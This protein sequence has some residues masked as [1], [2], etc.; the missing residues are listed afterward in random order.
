MALERM[1]IV[2]TFALNAA[3]TFALGLVVAKFLGP[4][5]FGRYAVA[6]SVATVINTAAFEWLRLSATRFYSE[7]ARRDDAGVRA[8]LALGYGA[9]VLTLAALLAAAALLRLDLGLPTGLLA[10]ATVAG[11]AMGLFDYQAALARARF[12]DRTYAALVLAKNALGFALMV[13]GAV[14]FGDPTLVLYGSALSALAA[15]VAARRAL[16]DPEARPSLARRDLIGGFARYALP[17]VAASFVYQLIPLL[18]RGFLASRFG[19]A[20]A[21]TFSLPADLGLRL[22]AT[23]GTG[24]DMLLFQIAVRTDETHGRDAARAQVA[25]NLALVAAVLFPVT[26]GF[27]LVLPS[28]EALVVPAAFRGGFAS[29]RALLIPALLALSLVQYALNP[30]FQL[31]KA[32]A[33]VTAAA[34][35]ALVV[36][37]GL[38]PVLTARFGPLGVAAAQAGGFVVASLVLTLLAAR[39]TALPWRDLALA[40]AATIAMTTALWPLRALPPGIA[41][42]SLTA[43][44]GVGIYGALALAFDIAGARAIAA[45]L[46]MRR[47]RSA[48]AE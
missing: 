2:V 39:T 44:A 42:L 1:T 46:R 35:A 18:N 9:I 22:F 25:R 24:M 40:A 38:L 30:V 43:A 14:L 16:A 36:D 31:R 21:G 37:A 32:T 33:P 17:L 26:A 13:G 8:T 3:L 4:D 27:W 45:R 29:Y 5:A 7:R 47:V 34:L 10:A 11:A 23:L 15:I 48:P 19:F 12:L 41:Q 28:F 6:L 20:E